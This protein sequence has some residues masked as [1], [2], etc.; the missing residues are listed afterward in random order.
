MKPIMRPTMWVATYAGFATGR[1]IKYDVAGQTPDEK[2]LIADFGGPNWP[3]WRVLQVKNGISG[4]WTGKF[5]SADA[6]LAFLSG[7]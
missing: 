5:G 4:G 6:A 1:V 3:R 2:Y 7:V